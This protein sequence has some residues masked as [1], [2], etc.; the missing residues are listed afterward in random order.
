M[1][2]TYA[3]YHAT[4]QREFFATYRSEN[5]GVIKMG[6]YGTTDII[7][8]CDINIKT[9]IGYKLMFKDVRYMINLRL[10]LISIRRL[11][12][13]DYDGIFRRGQ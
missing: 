3:F 13:E 5:F 7:S 6:N 9:N 2:D 10:N 4:L 8:M 1:I 11:D 12:D